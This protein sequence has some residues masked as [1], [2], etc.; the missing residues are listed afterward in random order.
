M[1]K[2]EEMANEKLYRWIVNILRTA[3]LDFIELHSHL[4]NALAYLQCKEALFKHC[5]DE[6]T[7]VRRCGVTHRFIEA[8]TRGRSSNNT[9][10]PAMEFYSNDIVRYIRDMFSFLHQTFVFERDMLKTLLK[11]CNQEE[12]AKKN[13]LKNII[14]AITE[15][16]F[17]CL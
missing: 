13:I 11:A 2:Y 8:L 12:L 1:A 7:I 10:Y 4:F 6:Y 17:F 15:G 14:S 5:L 16:D 3:N 9:N